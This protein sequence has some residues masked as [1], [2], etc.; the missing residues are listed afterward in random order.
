MSKIERRNTDLESVEISGPHVQPAGKKTAASVLQEIDAQRKKRDDVTDDWA[1]SELALYRASSMDTKSIYSF[2]FV[3]CR[4]DVFSNLYGITMIVISLFIQ[5]VVPIAI[6]ATLQPINDI[7]ETPRACPNRSNNLT[8]VIGFILSLYF[9]ILTI[10]LCTNKL[11]GLAFLKEFVYLGRSRTAI[12]EL[13]ILSQF[14]GMAAA[15]GAQYLLFIG[16]GDASYLIL[17]LQSLAMQF[18]LTVDQRLVSDMIGKR[19][20]ARL[21]KLSADDLLCDIG[22]GEEGQPVPPEILTKVKFLVKSEK[23]VLVMVCTVGL[24]WAI[25]LAVCI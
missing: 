10:S 19:T 22:V 23:F 14:I 24:A 8:K 4:E 13:G 12:V 2:C 6:I 5:T 18:C 11:R 15:G 20:N 7:V 1:R 3:E 17:L 9:V 16:N 25:A 21:S